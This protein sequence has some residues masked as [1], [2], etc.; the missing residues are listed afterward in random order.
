MVVQQP[1]NG[2]KYGQTRIKSSLLTMKNTKERSFL[3][4]AASGCLVLEGQFH[5]LEY[6]FDRGGIF[7]REAVAYP[8]SMH[9]HDKNHITGGA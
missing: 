9:Q 8:F 5:V 4:F 7:G 6:L 3:R 1:I 2:N